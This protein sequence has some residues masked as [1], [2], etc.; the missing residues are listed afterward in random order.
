M[1]PPRPVP[2]LNPVLVRCGG[3]NDHDSIEVSDGA[4][5]GMSLAA[6]ETQLS[7]R[8]L[9]SAPLILGSDLTTA[10]TNAYGTS[11][12]ITGRDFP[13]DAQPGAERGEPRGSLW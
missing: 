8:A 11:A 2:G 5:S 10:V 1:G 7:L 4:D 6:S 3:F 13:G 12:V 9:G